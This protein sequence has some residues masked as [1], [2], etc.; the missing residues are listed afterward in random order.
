MGLASN[1]EIEECCQEVW[2][3]KPGEGSACLRDVNLYVETS[4]CRCAS[5][6][7]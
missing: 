6:Q 3:N 4:C 7:A 5:M 1:S 2:Q